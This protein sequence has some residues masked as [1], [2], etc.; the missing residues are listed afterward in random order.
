MAAIT[1]QDIINNAGTI[2]TTALGIYE[3]IARAIP[4]VKDI[5]IVGNVIKV[6]N[7]LSDLLN[8]KK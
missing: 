8:K 7:T 2:I 1:F 5:T 6:L 3:V 4:T